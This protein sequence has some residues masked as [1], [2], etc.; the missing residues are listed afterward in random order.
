MSIPAERLAAIKRLPL[1]AKVPKSVSERL[2]R[3]AHLQHFGAGSVLFREGDAPDNL[4][5]PLDSRI[6][7]Q[8]GEGAQEHVIEF[9]PPGEPF[10][11]AAVILDKPFLMTARVVQAGTL[12]VIPAA[13]FRR[14][15]A[16]S[17]DLSQAV[18]ESAS[19][20]WRALIGQIKSLKMQTGPQRLAAFL[21]SLA[22][23]KSDEATV[24]LP[25][26]R[27]V[28]ATWL[29]MVPATA[30]R[31]FKELSRIGVEGRGQTLR[32]GSVRRLTDYTK[33][34]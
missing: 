24:E 6:C 9:V 13:D 33:G 29:G 21:A 20:Q 11:L 27:Q 16:Q 19:V 25:C 31:A 7:L 5:L 12:L 26:E 17:I 32:I 34:L 28:L 4:Y 22:D 23:G 2:L 14:C 30:S 3:S 10:I 8:A 18:N 1:L 15:S